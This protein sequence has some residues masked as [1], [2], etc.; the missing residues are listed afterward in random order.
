M[1][2]NV[3]L[4]LLAYGWKVW[5]RPVNHSQTKA[6]GGKD[7]R[8]LIT[9][10]YSEAGHVAHPQIVGLLVLLKPLVG[11]AGFFSRG[12]EQA[13]VEVQVQTEVGVLHFPE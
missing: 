4:T 12:S 13:V 11:F 1:L 6:S 7:G 2:V 8:V 9:Q 3:S 5:E 10:T